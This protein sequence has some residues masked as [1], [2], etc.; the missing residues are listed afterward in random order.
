MWNLKVTASG[1]MSN[2]Y[3]LELLRYIH[4]NTTKAGLIK[5]IDDC[6]WFSHHGY[7]A[8]Q[9]RRDWLYRDLVGQEESEGIHH[10]FS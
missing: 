2:H 7:A 10:F 6:R 4:R 8:D 5:T 1:L 9:Q 3:L